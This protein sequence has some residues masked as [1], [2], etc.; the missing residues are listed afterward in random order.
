[1]TVLGIILIAIGAIVRF[2]VT[3]A[4]EG[5]NLEVIGLVLMGAGVL[6]LIAGILTSERFSRSKTRVRVEE[7][8]NGREEVHEHSRGL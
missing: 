5:A 1:M 6:A 7:G 2:G 4:V 3:T 8:P